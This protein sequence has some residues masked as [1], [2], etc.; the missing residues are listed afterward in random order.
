MVGNGWLDGRDSWLDGRVDLLIGRYICLGYLAVTYL[1]RFPCR[2]RLGFTL[3]VLLWPTVLVSCTLSYYSDHTV[4]VSCTYC[5]L[6]PVSPG[7]G[8]GGVEGRFS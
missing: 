2:L 8:G 1:Q 7:R 6:S 5:P 3:S 4:L